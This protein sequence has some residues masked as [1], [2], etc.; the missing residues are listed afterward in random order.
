MAEPIE[1]RHA[2]NAAMERY[3]DGD[4]AAFE[5]VYDLLTPRLIAFFMRQVDDA[6]RAEELVE[7]TLLQMHAARRHYLRGSDVVPWSFAIARHILGLPAS[8]RDVDALVQEEGLS[9][10]ES[11][12]V[13]G[14]SKERAAT[15]LGRFFQILRAV[16]VGRA[17]P[18][19]E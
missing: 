15:R 19:A 14:T 3:A 7:R 10:A 5:E 8:E 6:P 12:E 9:L 2:L 1:T 16:F 11:V 17:G 4:D 13:L 18:V